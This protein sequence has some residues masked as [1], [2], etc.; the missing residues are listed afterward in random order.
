MFTHSGGK[1]PGCHSLFWRFWY[2]RD[3]GCLFKS[4]PLPLLPFSSLRPRRSVVTNDKA[5]QA[6]PTN[7]L[8]GLDLVHLSILLL[9]LLPLP[10]HKQPPRRPSLRLSF[11]Q[12]FFV[13]AIN[14]DPTISIYRRTFLSF[15]QI[16]PIPPSVLHSLQK[17][18]DKTHTHNIHPH[19][20]I[21]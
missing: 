16:D 20:I 12:K 17:R 2:R 13:V 19:I 18:K 14:N 21:T 7:C 3:P 15:D 9:L 6:K 1:F 4:S 8:T 5:R 11:N 10:P